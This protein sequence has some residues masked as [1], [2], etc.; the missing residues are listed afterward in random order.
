MN[1]EGVATNNDN[2]MYLHV[3]EVAL[4]KWS[5]LVQGIGEIITEDVENQQ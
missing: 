4:D 2:L 1:S 5:L 3:L